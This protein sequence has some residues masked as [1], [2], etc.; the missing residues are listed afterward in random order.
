MTDCVAKI[1]QVLTGRSGRNSL[2]TGC[3]GTNSDSISHVAQHVI[4]KPPGGK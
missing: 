2:A 4:L 3:P 1:E